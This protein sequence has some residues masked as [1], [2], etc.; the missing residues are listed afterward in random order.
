MGLYAV[1]RIVQLHGGRVD[2]RSKYGEWAEFSFEIPQPLPSEPEKEQGSWESQARK[3][4]HP[5]TP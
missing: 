1:W 5:D 2:A 4:P 3:L